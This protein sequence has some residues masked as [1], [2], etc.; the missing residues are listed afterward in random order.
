MPFVAFLSGAMVI[1]LSGVM[2]PGP[3]TAV[4]IGKGG[5][6][7]HAGAWIAVGHGIVEI[8]LMILL[9]LGIGRFLADPAVKIVFGALGGLFL[10]YMAVGLLRQAGRA[11]V[12]PAAFAGTPLAAGILLSL[13]NPYFFLWWATVGT[14]LILQSWEFGLA[15]FIGLCV[16]HWLCDFFW[17]YFLSALSFAGG[18]FFGNRFQRAVF[19]VCGVGLLFFGGRFLYDAVASLLA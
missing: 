1:S 15:G 10:L 16:G 6:S 8:P 14:A 3:V 2:A 7:P 4:T 13:G 19:A 17:G 9:A 11:A 5:R 12:A 18:K